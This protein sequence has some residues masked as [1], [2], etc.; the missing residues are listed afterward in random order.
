MKQMTAK[1][2]DI[3]GMV[4]VV[5]WQNECP[6][7]VDRERKC[8]HTKFRTFSARITLLRHKRRWHGLRV[9][10]ASTKPRLAGRLRPLADQQSANRKQA[11]D[12]T[13]IAWDQRREPTHTRDDAVQGPQAISANSPQ[14]IDIASE[15][16]QEK[17]C[18]V[19]GSWSRIGWR[20]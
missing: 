18:E 14:T 12:R 17:K 13:C 16:R 5:C 9:Y 3:E 6:Q 4:C 11:L 19:V 20:R 15:M 8:C 10:L 1:T 7:K 2:A